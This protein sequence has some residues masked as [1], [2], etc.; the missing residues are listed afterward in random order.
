[1]INSMKTI[2][3]RA[4][5][6]LLAAIPL[7]ANAHFVWLVPT[8]VEGQPRVCVYF[9]EDAHDNSAE[10]LSRVS[11]V[12]VHRIVGTAAAEAVELTKTA[13]QIST[14][15]SEGGLY[16]ASHDL[17]VM[18]RG[19]A[20]FRLLYYAKTGPKAGSAEWKSCV[21]SDDLMLDIVPHLQ[22]SQMAVTVTFREKPVANAELTVARPGAEDI[23]AMTNEQGQVTLDVADAGMYSLRAKFVENVAGELNGKAF[24]ETRHYSTVSLDV[25]TTGQRVEASRLQNLPQPVT[26]FG[27]AV[28]NDAVYTYGGHTGDAHSY[29]NKE[30]GNRLMKLSLKSGEWESLAEG[31]GLQGL[32]LVAHGNRLYRVGG[33]SAMN[34]EGED[35]DLWSQSDVACF[36]PADGKWHELPA[37]P[38]RR[39]SH[40]A[41]VVGDSIYV[42][43]G[44]AMKGEGDSAWHTTA[45][46]LDLTS[47]PL[48]WQPIAAPP[49]QRR[50]L[51]AAAHNGKLYAIG[52]MQEEGGPTTKTAVYDPASNKWSEGP[53]L[54]VQDEAK[55]EGKSSGESSKDSGQRRN[56]S[57]GMMTGFGAS[58][59]ATGGHLYA[60]T[61]QGTLQRLSED[62]SKWEVIGKTPTGRF[63]HRLLPLD[64]QRLIVV[65]GSNMSV[66]KYEEVEIIST[67]PQS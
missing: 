67:Q 34:K 32:A 24:P 40:D 12:A 7:T 16:V 61:V 30:Q 20:K 66:G 3:I 41:A 51:A 23:K 53:A 44:W 15:C 1:M 49:F 46:K 52:G 36:D 63:F 56:M 62:G 5:S 18:D 22:G 64:D 6:A 19:D 58:A 14:T 33:F 38:E 42:V 31:P 50:A 4:A 39:S 43:G 59:F 2:C 35:H 10:Y 21:T 54:V 37:L 65:G 11:G 9:G 26:S 28:L 47:Q 8:Q 27:A 29:S 17:G 48:R 25:P 55:P 45:W 13:E 57:G 60:T